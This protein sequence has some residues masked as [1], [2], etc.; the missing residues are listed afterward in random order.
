M[1][2]PGKGVFEKEGNMKPGFWGVI[3][4]MLTVAVAATPA[5]GGEPYIATASITG[6]A[7]Y[8]APGPDG[9]ISELP[10]LMLMS[11]SGLMGLGGGSANGI[12]DFDG[13][14]NRDYVM[15]IG[16]FSG[17]H[18]AYVIPKTGPGN[19]FGAP[20]LV[21]TYKE[22]YGPKGM[23]V[24]DFN[25]DD[26]LDF[27]VISSFSANALLFLNKAGGPGQEGVFAF[28]PVSLPGTSA[29]IGYGIDAADFNGDEK[30]D[31]IV[32]SFSPVYPCK[33]NINITVDENDP[34]FE[35]RDFIPPRYQNKGYYGVAAA[36]FIENDGITDLAFSNAGSLDI[37]EGDGS[38]SFTLAGS[39]TMPMHSSPIDN[40]DFDRDGKQDL[41]AGNFGTNSAS[42]VLLFG[43]GLGV[44]TY[45]PDD[46]Y[47]RGDLAARAAVTGL[48]FRFNIAP[49]A[50]LTPQAISVTVGETVEFDASA[51]SD[52]DGT[53]VSYHWDYGDGVMPA[54]HT[55]NADSSGEA[56]SSY[57]YFD[58]GTYYVTLTVTDDQGA[59][60]TVQA[61]VNVEALKLG[62]YISPRKLNLKSKGKWITA[63]I[64]VPAP[65]DARMIDPGSLWLVVGGKEI[66]AAKVYPYRWHRKHK[67]KYRRI[68]K[69]KAKF[70][71]QALIDALSNGDRGPT[72]LKVVGEI[73]TSEANLEC[74]GTCNITTYV[75][76]KK[77]SYR[78]YWKKWWSFFSKK[79]SR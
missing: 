11:N 70:D 36:D 76:E 30:V 2:A 6:D 74:A 43:D 52:E 77:K 79:K 34:Q 71:R 73:S 1:K 47:T 3:V 56:Q 31:F 54:A 65:Y 10:D 13:D 63:S 72:T 26:R 35:T 58:S 44:F 41:V 61:E 27:M 45:S 17:P 14:G 67:K 23:T 29:L 7:V 28:E 20:E 50:E 48:P 60:S 66:K 68:R 25:G 4:F 24:A 69:L 53:I 59:T 46:I 38:G 40:G 39:L 18:Y 57:V 32:A 55:V 64:R 22:G 51:S 62:V 9:I 8:M 49:V 21:Y 16:T 33:V 78:S 5:S 12:G 75:K 37:Y 42:T 15:A 19:Q